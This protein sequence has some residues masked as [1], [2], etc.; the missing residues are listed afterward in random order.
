MTVTEML[1]RPAGERPRIDYRRVF[2]WLPI[3]T[4]DEGRVWLNWVW[5]IEAS[6]GG[7]TFSKAILP[8]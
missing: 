4:V 7:I 2:A 1:M 6:T 3:E 8:L 5:R